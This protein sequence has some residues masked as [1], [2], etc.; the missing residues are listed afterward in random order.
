[1][2]SIITILCCFLCATMSTGQER[3]LT[4]NGTI[5]F[6]SKAPI[7][8][9]TADNNQVLSIIDATNNQMAISILM[10]SF[11]FKKAL[12]QEH[13]NENYVESDKYPKATFK[14]DLLNF[15]AVNETVRV[16]KVKGILTIHGISKEI[17]IDANMAKIKEAIL[18]DGEFIINLADFEIEIPA[19]VANN[20]AK[21]IRVS[22]NFNH[23]P[24]NK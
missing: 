5:N 7:E 14:G 3:Y 15:D 21:N 6:F 2:K 13:F 1:M 11:L 18:V 9:I 12:M 10:K 16:V 8:N 20:I 4:K 19:V 22:F 24:Y 23:E 17:T